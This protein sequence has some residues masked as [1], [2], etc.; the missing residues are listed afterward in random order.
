MLFFYRLRV[1]ACL[2]GGGL[3]V[4]QQVFTNLLPG[5]GSVVLNSRCWWLFRNRN[6]LQPQQAVQLNELLAANQRLVTVYAL[7]DES[8]RAGVSKHIKAALGH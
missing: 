4:L 5:F 1:V 8:G 7:C 2:L 6:K 3:C